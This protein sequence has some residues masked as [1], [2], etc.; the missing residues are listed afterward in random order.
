[1]SA[2]RLAHLSCCVD[3]FRQELL[4]LVL[5]FMA[6]CVLDR[7]VVALDEVPFAVLDGQGGFACGRKGRSAGGRHRRFLRLGEIA[8]RE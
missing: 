8:A 7:R 4:V 2:K 1:M 5:N 6:E 3:D